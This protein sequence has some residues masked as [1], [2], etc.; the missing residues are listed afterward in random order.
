MAIWFAA[1]CAALLLIVGAVGRTALEPKSADF[2]TL[3][4]ARPVAP[5]PRNRPS[6]DSPAPAA[7]RAT[8]TPLAES[9]SQVA[10]DTRQIRQDTS[11]LADAGRQLTRDTQRMADT[12]DD[13]R[14]AFLAAARHDGLIADPRTAGEVYHNARLAAQQGNYAAARDFYVR[15][16]GMGAEFVD[17]HQRFQEFLVLQE[18]RAGARL[19]Y[20][21]LPGDSN[22]VVRRYATALLEELPIRREQLTSLRRERPDFA[23]ATYA[24]SRCCSRSELGE[25]SLT[26]QLTEKELLEAFLAQQREGQLLRYFLDQSD[27][28]AMIEDAQQRLASLQSL[29]PELRDR[30]VSLAVTQRPSGWMLVFHI[31]EAAREIQYRLDP[32]GPF[33]STGL[34]DLAD[35]RTGSRPP[36]TYVTLP[37]N[38]PPNTLEVRY[39]DIHGT[40]RGPFPLTFDPAG[41]TL[42]GAKRELELTKSAWARFGTGVHANRLYFSH[43][44]AYREAIAEVRYAIDQEAP[45]ITFP[46]PDPADGDSVQF[47]I[48]VPPAARFA[49]VQVTFRDGSQSDVV[50]CE[51]DNR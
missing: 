20:R 10:E 23:P 31:A 19:L 36:K 21:E 35:P 15:L 17:V 47:H 45:S 32:T 44:A 2:R 43:L 25:Q 50:R 39:T 13:L 30:P 12:L 22:H 6:L 34:A 16:L 26:D 49:V 27:A 7:S 14:A 9:L 5:T 11:S 51:R 4:I 42:R 28:A 37:G 29:A 1:A 24:L 3:P 41:E 33:V 48:D 38:T 40:M 46:L 8:A 18:G